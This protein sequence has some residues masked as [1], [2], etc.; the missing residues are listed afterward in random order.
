MRRGQHARSTSG[1][2]SR[3]PVRGL[4]WE[5][6]EER[7][8]DS[9]RG[10]RVHR[11]LRGRLGPARARRPHHDPRRRW[12][13]ARHRLAAR[14][15]AGRSRARRPSAL[16]S[17]VDILPRVV[18]RGR[19]CSRRD[20][21]GHRQ[22]RWAIDVAG[23]GARLWRAAPDA[24]SRALPRR[25]P[26]RVGRRHAGGG[27]FL[28]PDLRRDDPPAAGL[29]AR[30]VRGR[31]ASGGILPGVDR[32]ARSRSGGAGRGRRP[33]H[34][35]ELRR[36][37]RAARAVAASDGR[38]PRPARRWGAHRLWP[39]TW[40]GHLGRPRRAGRLPGWWR[41]V[42]RGDRPQP[43]GVRSPALRAASQLHPAIGVGLRGP[44]RFR[45]LH[46]G[47]QQGAR[48][49]HDALCRRAA[50][51]AAPPGRRLRHRSAKGRCARD[52]EP[53]GRRAEL[54]RRGLARQLLRS[55]SVGDR[56]VR[57]LPR[58]DLHVGRHL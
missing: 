7:T 17:G 35:R 57:R 40:A 46:S 41:V 5:R 45:A 8:R 42:D 43:A 31:R 10:V 28:C 37:P 53:G 14:A 3:T 16:R 34:A 47:R 58:W 44:A 23:G 30:R 24:V 36:L 56:H 55:W 12:R 33:A 39:G 18:S 4:R 6:P 49:R 19:A 38:T 26:Y 29:D 52:M 25:Q 15:R 20:L 9:L 22:R 50:R 51:A 27:V 1:A 13:R 11:H 32:G 21:R 54:L 2:H 48:V